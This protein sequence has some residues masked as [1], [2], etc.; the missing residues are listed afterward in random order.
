MAIKEAEQRIRS[1]L[2]R[3]IEKC[4]IQNIDLV[5]YGTFRNQAIQKEWNKTS[6]KMHDRE[7][8]TF[9]PGEEINLAAV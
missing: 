8:S 1:L 3:Y 6:P 2:P 7:G 4:T 9:A 5:H